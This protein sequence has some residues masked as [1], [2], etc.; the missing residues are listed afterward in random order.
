[1]PCSR[2]YHMRLKRK[3]FERGAEEVARELLGK[4]LVRVIRE[5]GVIRAIITETEA[6]VGEHDLASHVRFGRTKRNEVMYGKGGGVYMFFTYGVHWMLNFVTSRVDDPQAVL[7]RGLRIEGG[8]TS[9]SINGP[10]KVTKYLQLDGSFYCENLETSD[11]LWVED[12]GQARMTN[13]EVV[14]TSRIGVPY[15]KQ[16]KNK[17]LR[18]LLRSGTK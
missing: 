15:A 17:K 14:T 11:R 9:Q 16:W 12:S 5:R 8:V 4:V 1:M 10:G 18:F 6:Y 2:I 7:I 13:V 3:F